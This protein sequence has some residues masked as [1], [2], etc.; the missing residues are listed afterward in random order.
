MRYVKAIF[1]GITPRSPAEWVIVPICAVLLAYTG[2]LALF[3]DV[4]RAVV[5]SDTQ[6]PKIVERNS[7]FWLSFDITFDQTCTMNVQRIIRGSDRVEYV[8]SEEKR[9]V[10]AGVPVKYSVR[11]PITPAIP[12]GVGFVRSD[13]KWNCDYWS[14]W[15]NP[16]AQRGRER[17]ITIV[18]PSTDVILR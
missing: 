5:N 13:F 12:Y 18:P 14:T 3:K 1:H 4:P 10:F 7:Y 6:Y 9:Q 8:A 17:S 11:V 15:I 16:R 2:Y